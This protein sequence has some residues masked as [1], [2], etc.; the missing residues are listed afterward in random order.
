[1]NLEKF[2]SKL[3]DEIRGKLRKIAEGKTYLVLQTSII[4]NTTIIAAYL[5]TNY[6]RGSYGQVKDSVTLY[7]ITQS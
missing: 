4:G 7:K 1:M 6:S 2:I 5:N 3:L